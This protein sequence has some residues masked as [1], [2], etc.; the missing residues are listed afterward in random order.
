[1]C[2]SGSFTIGMTS[3]RCPFSKNCG[4]AMATKGRVLL[5]EA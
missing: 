5:V 1:M 3:G 2:L 4:T